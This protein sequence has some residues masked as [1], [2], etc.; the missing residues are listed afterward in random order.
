MS[1]AKNLSLSV[2]FQFLNI[3]TV[4]LIG[5]L[6]VPIIINLI[7]KEYYGVLEIIL[8]L[9]IINFF[10]ELGMGSTL[11]RFVP[12]YQKEGSYKLNKF[13]WT[14]LYFKSIL[15]LIAALVIICIGFYFDVFFNLGKSDVEVVQKAV[16][17]FA[18][19][20]FITNFAT[21]FS[22][23]LKG[24]QRFDLGI[25]PDLISQIFFLASIYILKAKGVNNVNLL[26]VS[27]IM[28]VLRPLIRI[29]FSITFIKKFAPNIKLLPV[30]P[31]F[32]YIKESLNFLKGMSF[33]ALFAQFYT[34]TPKI[35]LG[36]MLNPI[37]V[38]YWGIAE[39][40]RN[41]LDQINS[42]LIRPLIPM[43]S[44]MDLDQEQNTS[45]WIINITKVHFLLI[46]GI[47]SFVLLYINPFL[48]IWL[49]EDYLYVGNIVRIWF[50][51]FVLPNASV[52]LMFY[53][54]K[55]KTKLSQYMNIFNSFLGLFL[56]SILINKYDSAGLAFGLV[57]S[58]SLTMIV[59]FYYLCL[60]FK[61]SFYSI[62]RKAYLLSYIVLGLTMFLNYLLINYIQVNNWTKLIFSVSTGIFI[63]LLL[64][65]MSL[66]QTEKKYYIKVIT[67]LLNKDN[68]N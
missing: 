12:I 38:A 5:I 18:I 23:V 36:I 14:Y 34:N 8:S 27:V 60:E 1:R 25:I 59:Y 9:M 22:N 6:V 65:F 20:I 13:I 40:I 31:E 45:S 33:I 35:I 26:H 41:P 58:V 61:L 43:A 52:L 44:S 11:L 64:L 53:Y 39:R 4:G 10:F 16:Y 54:A 42:S 48:K 15:A 47:A 50:I 62:F 37:S 55:G 49:G 17:I 3:V 46:G 51:P 19:G 29:F 30:R 32:S 66:N 67:L 24:F 57:F 28:F 21:Y 2:I 7:G 68:N 63:Y 56:G